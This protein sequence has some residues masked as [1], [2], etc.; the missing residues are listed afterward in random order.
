M[1]ILGLDLGISS[2][3]S[4]LIDYNKENLEK[5]LFFMQEEG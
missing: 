3:G 5:V 2:V 4:A 1:K